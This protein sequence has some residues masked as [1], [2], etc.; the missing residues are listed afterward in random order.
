MAVFVWAAGN[1]QF[2]EHNYLQRLLRSQ[3]RK[4]CSGCGPT[5]RNCWTPSVLILLLLCWCMFSW[6]QCCHVPQVTGPVVAQELLTVRCFQ[7]KSRSENCMIKSMSGCKK[8][9]PTLKP[10]EGCCCLWELWKFLRFLKSEKAT[11]ISANGQSEYTTR[12]CNNLVHSLW[13]ICVGIT[14]CLSSQTVDLH[15]TTEAL[16]WGS[17]AFSSGTVQ[18][19]PYFTF[20][21]CIEIWLCIKV[22]MC[23][24][25]CTGMEE[26]LAFQTGICWYL[27]GFF[28]RIGL[29]TTKE[30]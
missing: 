9:T 21:K 25:Y 24:A 27:L 30:Q 28:S 13:K 18:E 8:R 6:A 26:K 22:C 7:A 19:K 4:K 23:F 29:S 3:T 1:Q 17:I 12:T 15:L 20:F 2:C 10:L 5:K 16:N 14:F 11:S